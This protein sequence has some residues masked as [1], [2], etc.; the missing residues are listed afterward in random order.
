M[1]QRNLETGYEYTHNRKRS[2][3]NRVHVTL[4]HNGAPRQATRYPGGTVNSQRNETP[5]SNP[6][7]WVKMREE[8]ERGRELQRRGEQDRRGGDDRRGEQDR[9]GEEDGQGEEERRAEEGDTN[10]GARSGVNTETSETH[11]GEGRES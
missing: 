4:F 1:N 5:S 2:Y 11:T 9:R 10:E 8:D 6:D 7:I 3:C